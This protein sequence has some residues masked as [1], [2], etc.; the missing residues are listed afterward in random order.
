MQQFLKYLEN[1]VALKVEKLA[2]YKHMESLDNDLI[3]KKSI[4]N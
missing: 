4:I 1:Y 3:L 2:K